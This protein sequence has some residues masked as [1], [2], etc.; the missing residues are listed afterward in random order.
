MRAERLAE[1]EAAALVAIVRVSFWLTS[2]AATRRLLGRVAA[3]RSDRHASDHAVAAVRVGAATRAAARRLP[4]TTCLVEALA[5][6]AMLRRRGVA[7]TLHIGVRAPVLATPLDAHAWLECD[8]VV[9]VGDS[10]DLAHYR[11]LTRPS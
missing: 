1:L 5:A 8:G 9:V 4:G 7:S 3:H 2:Y 10:A 11:V 6:E